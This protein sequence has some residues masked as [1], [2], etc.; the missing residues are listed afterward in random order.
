M[1][2]PQ[3]SSGTATA[4]TRNTPPKQS[5]ETKQFLENPTRGAPGFAGNPH[6]LPDPRLRASARPSFERVFPQELA[7]KSKFWPDALKPRL[8][9]HAG[10]LSFCCALLTTGR[11]FVGEL[12]CGEPPI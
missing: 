12:A 2:E 7:G 9:N 11:Y 6:R 4:Q 5:A 1:I 8:L 3:F 10:G